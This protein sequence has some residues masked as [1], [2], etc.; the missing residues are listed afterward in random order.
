MKSKEELGILLLSVLFLISI[1]VFN[2]SLASKSENRE[3]PRVVFY[4]SWFDVSEPV[5]DGL[6]GVELVN[7]D[8]DGS[9]ERNTV[10]YDPAFISIDE[11]E[12]ALKEV[13]VYL[14]TAK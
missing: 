5:L 12:M 10:W 3:L 8:Y 2:G 9:R 13:G 4:V 11:M 6:K 7:S 1:L 14:E